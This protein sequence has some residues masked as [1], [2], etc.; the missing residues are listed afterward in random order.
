MITIG[1]LAP[2]IIHGLTVPG[3]PTHE[4]EYHVIHTLGWSLQ[5]TSIT[6]T[7]DVATERMYYGKVRINCDIE[8]G[9]GPPNH[10]FKATIIWE[11][12]NHCRIFDVGRSH[13][14]MIKFK[15]RYFTETLENNE[16]GHKSGHKPHIP[17]YTTTM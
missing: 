9:H 11:P 10:A 8:R 7:F 16:T 5:L 14:R 4:H 12:E 13:A 15:K 3:K 17:F 1:A 6:L 2:K